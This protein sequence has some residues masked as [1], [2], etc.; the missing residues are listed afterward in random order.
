MKANLHLTDDQLAAK[1]GR[2][3]R[4]IKNARWRYRIKKQENRGSF[5]KGSI[6][7][8]KGRAYYAGG[9]SM[10]TQF[11][12]GHKK[13][14]ERPLY[15]VF[16]RGEHGKKHLFIKI[17]GNRHYPYSRYMWETKTG[18]KLAKNEIIRFKDGNPLN[19]S[20]KNLLKMTRAE[21]AE[22]NINRSKAGETLRKVWAV[23]KTFEDFGLTPPYKFKSKRKSA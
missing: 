23:V 3:V 19:C 4:S 2:D 12:A 7:W 10:Q 1:L 5:K 14:G 21:N 13:P 17:P 18:K 16:E 8:N 6:P 11:K 20:F 15:T 9:R 22:K